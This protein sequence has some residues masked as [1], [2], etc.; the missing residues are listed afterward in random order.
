[1][2]TPHPNAGPARKLLGRTAVLSGLLF[3]AFALLALYLGRDFRIGTATRMGT[4]YVP[5]L[6]AWTLLGLG[7]LTLLQGLL[8]TKNAETIGDEPAP[9]RPLIAVTASVL[10]FGFL[11][12]RTGLV[13]AIIATVGIGSLAVPG[14]SPLKVV[15]AAVIL[16]AASV[17]IFPYALSLTMPVWPVF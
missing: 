16:A 3:I 15:V 13:I 10:A 14:Q 11:L 5:R 7:A 12:E 1:M 6:V 9:W 4:G 2:G 8:P 17:A